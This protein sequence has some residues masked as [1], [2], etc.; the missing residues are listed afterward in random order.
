MKRRVRIEECPEGDE[1]IVIRCR[2]VT[3]EILALQKRLEQSD[4]G[5]GLRVIGLKMGESECFVPTDRILF[6]VTEGSRTVAHTADRI[7]CTGYRLYE[8]TDRL[9]SS[10]IR[11]SKSCVLNTARV[12]EVRRGVTGIGEVFFEGSNKRAFVSRMYYPAF[13]Q[14]LEEARLKSSG[15]IG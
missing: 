15:S 1:E 4:D 9:P 13:R 8:L 5:T 14:T 7:Y 3:P 6:F 10:F 12:C 11:A 2:T